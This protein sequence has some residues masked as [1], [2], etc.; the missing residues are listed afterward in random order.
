MA[1]TMAK[2][3][4]RLQIPMREFV[5]PIA[6]AALSLASNNARMINAL[7]PP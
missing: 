4:M 5:A 7:I 3:R 6:S 1:G 2:D